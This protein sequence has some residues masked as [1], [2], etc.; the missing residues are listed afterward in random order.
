MANNLLGKVLVA[1]KELNGPRPH[2]CFL[3]EESWEGSGPLDVRLFFTT[4]YDADW[5]VKLLN[6][7]RHCHAEKTPGGKVVVSEG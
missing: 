7:Y 4:D 6:D 1:L 5:A 3:G 2:S